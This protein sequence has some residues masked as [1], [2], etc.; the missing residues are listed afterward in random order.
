[1]RRRRHIVLHVIFRCTL[2]DTLRILTPTRTTAALFFVL[3][4]LGLLNPLSRL[5]L[6]R[7]FFL[8]LDIH[9]T[10]GTVVSDASWTSAVAPSRDES[11][12]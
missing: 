4:T 12:C 9:R 11:D 1:M 2:A 6:T 5:L 10:R 8:A 7:R 3:S